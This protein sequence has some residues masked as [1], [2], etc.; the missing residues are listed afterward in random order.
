MTV[1]SIFF[2]FFLK[3]AGIPMEVFKVSVY[4][5]A[6]S[7]LGIVNLAAACPTGEP[8]TYF[9]ISIKVQNCQ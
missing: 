5:K 2:I 6:E 9:T 3:V 4:N 1:S 8:Q 7:G